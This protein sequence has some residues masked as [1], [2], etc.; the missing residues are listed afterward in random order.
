MHAANEKQGKKSGWWRAGHNCGQACGG[1]ILTMRDA[2]VKRAPQRI[3][4]EK[5]GFEGC[6]GIAHIPTNNKSC[7][8]APNNEKKNKNKQISK[9]CKSV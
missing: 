9:C 2:L 6:P 5:W 8:C 7:Y 4:G 3:L 1:E